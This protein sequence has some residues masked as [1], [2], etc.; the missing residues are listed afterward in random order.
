MK[1]LG[2]Y[3]FVIIGDCYNL[4]DLWTKMLNLPLL[5]VRYNRVFI[6]NR[7]CY[8]LVSLWFLISVLTHQ[9]N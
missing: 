2:P 3:L 7:D 8:N 5:Y 6:N 1:S 9:Q 4:V